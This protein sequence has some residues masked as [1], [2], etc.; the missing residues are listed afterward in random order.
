VGPEVGGRGAIHPA[1]PSSALVWFRRDL[2]AA[3][4]A[5]LHHALKAARRVWCVFVYDID[6][7]GPLPRADRRVAFIH[8]SVADL[9]RQLERVAAAFGRDPVRLIVRHG[10]AAE[11]IPRLANTLGVQAVYFNHD[12]EPAALRR[13]AKVRDGLRGVGVAVHSFKDHVIFER[14]EVLTGTGTPYSVFTP[15]K[16]AW[17]KKLEPGSLQGHPVA[18]YGASLAPVPPEV[19]SAPPTLQQIGF[20]PTDL[21]A[22]GIHT[23][24]EGAARLL[25]DFLQR[26]D[27]YADARDFPARQG[28]SQLSV[29]LR[30][31]TPNARPCG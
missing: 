14:S 26:I 6:I 3:D 23:G 18:A 5:A 4:N 10:L 17:L 11:E 31:G 19:A 7:L 12:D 15:Y 1:A 13:D 21:E 25:D 20:E 27:A 2:R 24:S 22:L 9:N 8:A 16:N 30:F 29:H 28:S